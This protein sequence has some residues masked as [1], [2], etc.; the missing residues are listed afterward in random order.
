VKAQWRRFRYD[1][2][3]V[4]PWFRDDLRASLGLRTRLP[5]QR[6]ALR[7]LQRPLP[8]DDR[9]FYYP[10]HFE[11]EAMIDLFG[12]HARDQLKVIRRVSD[13]LPAGH[14]LCV[15]EHPWMSP[16]ARRLGYYETI[17]DLGNV[18]LLDQR[19][20]GYEVIRRCRGVVT[21]AG[22]TGFEALFYGKR[23]LVFGRAFYDAFGDGV[24]RATSFEQTAAALL[25]MTRQPALDAGA[26]DRF[27]VALY[28]RSYPGLFALTSP[29]VD[30]PG[31]HTA[32]AR[33]MVAELRE[34]LTWRAEAQPA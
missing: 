1:D 32:V 23:V 4:D 33:A 27:V 25:D 15:K 17:A 18:R 29:G 22:T 11:P 6:R 24:M 28:Q 20:D 16:G 7:R 26:V 2:W 14:T 12:T 13:A 21:I 5:L 9:F 34:R 3:F 31:N 30:V 8:D 10:L 19:T